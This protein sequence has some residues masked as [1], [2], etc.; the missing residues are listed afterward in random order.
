MVPVA[1]QIG[2]VAVRAVLH[3]IGVA[4]SLDVAIL[5]MEAA[6]PGTA[7]NVHLRQLTA[8]LAAAKRGLV[9]MRADATRLQ[10]RLAQCQTEAT[11]WQSR[12]ERALEVGD[13]AL[14]RQALARKL[15]VQRLAG[16]YAEQQTA[17]QRALDQVQAAVTQWEARL[18][19]VQTARAHGWV[20]HRASLATV[21]AQRIE[22]VVQQMPPTWRTEGMLEAQFEQF[23]LDQAMDA[24]R[25]TVQG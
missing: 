18:R 1:R 9:M 2:D 8:E 12:A 14:A 17:Q 5:L 4:I 6:S 20:S 16:Q 10:L 7:G 23:D 21:A 13:E 22:Q 3:R 19:A 25:R 11:T 24:L 15:H